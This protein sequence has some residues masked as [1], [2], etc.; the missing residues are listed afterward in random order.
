MIYIELFKVM[1]KFNVNILLKG[2][3]KWQTYSI[4]MNGCKAKQK[5]KKN[6]LIKTLSEKTSASNFLW[7][8]S[9]LSL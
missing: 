5:N 3:A 1:S 6:C 7:T 2:F 9:N 8:H 4:G